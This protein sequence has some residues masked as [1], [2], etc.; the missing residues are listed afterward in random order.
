MAVL[1]FRA[2]TGDA[3]SK[4]AKEK[5]R[6]KERRKETKEKRCGMLRIVEA[7]TKFSFLG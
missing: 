7:S 1:T 3:V 4:R 2:K 5:R 6:V